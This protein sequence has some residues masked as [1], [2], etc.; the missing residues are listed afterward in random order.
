M[1]R[2]VGRLCSP[3]FY[4]H[5]H[6]VIL[7]TS[8]RILCLPMSYPEALSC[9][10]NSSAAL[11][12]SIYCMVFSCHTLLRILLLLTCCHTRQGCCARCTAL[13]AAQAGSGKR[14]LQQLVAVADPRTGKGLIQA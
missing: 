10:E 11:W 5:C 6:P 1:P 2:E 4:R 12:V 13:D 7:P 3:I 9:S 14:H 8:Y